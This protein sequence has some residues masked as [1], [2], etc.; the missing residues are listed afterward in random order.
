MKSIHVIYHTCSL[1]GFFSSENLPLFSKNCFVLIA[2][3]VKKSCLFWIITLQMFLQIPLIDRIS[4][5][6]YIERWKQPIPVISFNLLPDMFISLPLEKKRKTILHI[7]YFSFDYYWIKFFISTLIKVNR[8]CI[9]Y[10]IATQLIS[11]W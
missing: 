9:L 2:L 11:L 4:S 7:Q 5:T 10:L 1:L 3:V 8:A 6:F